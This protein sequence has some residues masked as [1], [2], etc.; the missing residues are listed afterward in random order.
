[1]KT[2]AI[3][4]ISNMRLMNRVRNIFMLLILLV[5]S[6]QGAWAI[7]GEW[8]D[9][10]AT[11]F[12]SG[13]G[14]KED[15]YVIKTA[16]QLAYMAKDISDNQNA[17][18]K[19]YYA[20]EA[21]IDLGAHYWNAIGDG[22]DLHG[23]GDDAK[24]R[25]KGN[26]DGR[27]HVIKNM[28][29]QWIANGWKS[30]GLFGAI[31]GQKDS[32]A[33]VKNLVIDN[34]N[35]ERISGDVAGS[36]YMIGILAGEARQYSE[37]SNI[38]V[39][40]SVQS[41]GGSSFQV[42]GDGTIRFGGILGNLE[43]NNQYYRIFNLAAINVK[44]K[45]SNMSYTSSKTNSRI[46]TIIGRFRQQK[47]TDTN[48]IFAKNIFSS[49][50][51]ELNQEK[52]T[53]GVIRGDV[54]TFDSG[55]NAPDNW[56][57]TNSFTSSETNATNY[58]EKKVLASYGSTFS[59]QANGFL[60]EK[61]I[62][63]APCW[64]YDQ[65]SGF[66]FGTLSGT[67]ES[68]HLTNA[69]VYTVN[70]PIPGSYTYEW[71]VGGVRQSSTTNTATLLT[72]A[73]K[74]NGRVVIKKGSETLAEMNFVIPA[75]IYGVEDH[76]YANSYAGGNGTQE[77]PYIIS[78]DIQLAKLALDVS[79]GQNTD[80]Y[81][82]ITA[83]IDLSKA[84]WT[85]IGS[86]VYD[87]NKTFKGFLDGVGHTIKNMRFDWYNPISD[88]CRFGL[89]TTIEGTSE[90]WSDVKNLI[91]DNAKIKCD[92]A[93]KLAQT[94]YVG[95]LVG[96]IRNYSK[97]QNIIVR[98]SQ[99]TGPSSP[100]AQNGQYLVLGGLAAYISD[101][102]NNYNLN[103]IAVDV[104]INVEQLD[105]N[106]AAKVYIGG[107]I[108]ECQK[109]VKT[110]V[111]NVYSQS[112]I[113]VP[114]SC[115]NV[116]S[117]FGIYFDNVSQT[118][119]YYVNDA[120]KVQGT[121][122]ALN[123][124]AVSFCNANN[125][126]IRS[127]DLH[128]FSFWHFRTTSK[129][130]YLD[131]LNTELTVDKKSKIVVTA[132]TWG[133]TGNENYNWY[134]SEDNVTWKKSNLSTTKILNLP[135]EGNV[136]YVYAEVADGSSRSSSVKISTIIKANAFLT[137]TNGTYGVNLTNSLWNDDNQYLEVSY[138]WKENDSVIPGAT[139]DIYTPSGANEKVACHVILRSGEYTI[140]DKTLFSATVVFIKPEGGD[141]NNSGLDDQ[142]PVKT[143]QKAYS[144]LNVEGS[145]DENTIVLM[146]LSNAA[147]TGTDGGF[148]IT[149]NIVN[150]EPSELYSA[151]KAKV[152]AS[153]LAKNATIT[154]KYKDVDY[155]AVI[156]GSDTK[157][158]KYISLFGDTRFEYITFHHTNSSP[159]DGGNLNITFPISYPINC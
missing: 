109:N 78:N 14:T 114:S 71:Y 19:K 35:V 25:F 104:N 17:S 70:I 131:R 151:W 140:L 90:K 108:A 65:T 64:V 103:N 101:N 98:N 15:P 158:K 147:A 39:K 69:H 7:S 40:N 21:D 72:K 26:F 75:E 137:N 88:K 22:R 119:L 56:Y 67:H 125:D 52:I 47:G 102:N 44:M 33:C 27:G 157:G 132:S 127:K 159:G 146:G 92:N 18:L 1:M 141:D 55:T 142:H 10:A 74:Q 156:E 152:D 112:T 97:I 135:Y 110:C 13:S 84:I 107:F 76:L 105:V 106:N 80:K 20:L 126:Y 133:M 12:A 89:F 58:G 77:S 123:G 62:S 43:Q 130:F 87:T 11:A 68:T 73:V 24:Y 61:E 4:K 36:Y 9:N 83:D 150:N 48:C 94:R 37:I 79:K 145:W 124:F 16:A 129:E 57:Y 121:Q 113:K 8:K 30:T 85:P 34:A 32:W 93:S 53:K 138:Q 42:G 128:D 63:D 54:F 143:W 148:A 45:Y 134:I 120:K 46:G 29:L 2:T 139:S 111:N 91:I 60:L 49:V 81:Y 99:I 51:I 122:K 115:E 5:T 50:T 23:V 149:K 154:G 28:H 144:L 136:K 3:V 96:V 117:V 155:G 41:D 59:N 86:Y 66:A 38:I 100:F 31:V 153:H 6:V 116:G 82:R 95:T 118:T